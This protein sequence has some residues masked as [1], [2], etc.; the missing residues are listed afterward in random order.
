M[1]Q[2]DLQLLEAVFDLVVT[3]TETNLTG[4]FSHLCADAWRQF[5]QDGRHIIDSYHAAACTGVQ[6]GQSG[7]LCIWSY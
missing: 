4:N 7:G 1:F 3:K 5:S 6:N 2:W